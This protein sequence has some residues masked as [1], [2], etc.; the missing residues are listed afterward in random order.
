M[1]V[2]VHLAL[3]SWTTFQLLEGEQE[4]RDGIYQNGVIDTPFVTVSVDENITVYDKTTHEARKMLFAL[5]TVVTLEMSTSTSNQKEQS[6][7]T[8]N[9]KGCEVL[10]NTACF[11]KILLKHELTI[12]VSADE[13]WMENKEA[14]SS[15]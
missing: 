5:K 3:L 12:P 2:P 15:L 8:Q 10:E 4:G 11:A 1:T 9:S 14:S 13:N 7:S 6:L